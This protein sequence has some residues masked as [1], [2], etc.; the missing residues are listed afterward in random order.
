MSVPKNRGA[1]WDTTQEE[2]I[3]SFLRQNISIHDISTKMGRSVGAIKSRIRAIVRRLFNE[4]NSENDIMEQTTLSANIVREIV[5]GRA[6]DTL[7]T[8][9]KIINTAAGSTNH[10][11]DV[12]ESPSNLEDTKQ[13]IENLLDEFVCKK[14][15]E[16]IRQY[17]TYYRDNEPGTENIDAWNEWAQNKNLSFH[18]I[19]L[20]N[21]IIQAITD[22]DI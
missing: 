12:K 6:F 4:D 10:V 5:K 21:E 18:A 2:Q 9:S 20:V 8:D 19:K 22:P 1:R 15:T 13:E 11:N 3:L 7:E 16:K 17:K 14:L